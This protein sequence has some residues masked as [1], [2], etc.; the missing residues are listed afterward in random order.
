MFSTRP[1][2]GAIQLGYEATRLGVYRSV[3]QTFRS[4]IPAPLALQS[5]NTNTITAWQGWPR[6]R[7]P[8]NGGW[9][10]LS[11]ARQFCNDIDRFEVAI[12]SKNDLCGLALGSPSRARTNLNVHIVEGA[13]WLHPLRGWITPLVLE[14][15]VSYG[16]AFGC[17]WLRFIEPNPRMRQQLNTLGFRYV[18]QT[19]RKLT[20]YSERQL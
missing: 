7:T 13:P 14:T 15:A 8:P 4:I 12:W 6:R 17:T 18:L 1:T 20:P 19:N 10:W 5:M 16:I 2:I 11:W 3:E 9:N